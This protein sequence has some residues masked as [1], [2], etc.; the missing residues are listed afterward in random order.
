MGRFS[1][2]LH[3]K[4]MFVS[5]VFLVGATFAT[6]VKIPDGPQ[7][8][9]GAILKYD[10]LSNSQPGINYPG[11][12]IG[13]FVAQNWPP[14][15]VN[16]EDQAYT[17]DAA[18][19]DGNTGEITIK[20]EKHSDG[21]ITSARLESYQVW[22]TAQSEDIKMRGYVEVRSTLPAKV[23][24]GH[25]KGSWPAIWMLGTGNGHDWPTHG[26]I[27]IVEA[28]NGDP[29]IFMTIHSTHHNGGNGQ[30][31]DTSNY[32]AN[33]DFTQYPLIAGF[34][35]NIRPEVGQIDLTWWMTWFDVSSQSW[36]S[37]H[38]T[39]VLF[40][41][42]NNDYWD[43]FNSFNGEGFSLLINL[44]EGGVMPGTHDTFVDGQ[45]QFMHVSSVKVYG[46]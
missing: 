2:K 37:Q 34:E 9:S 12:H 26:E 7:G 23:D 14:G 45:P 18:T 19:Q 6:S 22:S 17:E 36:E 28:V 30:H 31:P 27:D 20:A 32:W 41:N 21:S 42:G 38:T 35:W 1:R 5:F 4:I 44:A 25:L 10:L 8:P 3:M 46:F 39:K 43:F 24:G 40:E 16:D 13:A 11:T 15:V 33:S 29:K